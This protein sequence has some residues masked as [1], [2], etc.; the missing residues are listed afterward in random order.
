MLRKWK[1]QVGRHSN[2][3]VTLAHTSMPRIATGAAGGLA[4]ALVAASTC[5]VEDDDAASAVTA[6][7]D[8]DG[9]CD[10]ADE[11]C[12][13]D[14]VATAA[15]VGSFVDAETSGAEGK[16]GSAK[17]GSTVCTRA[18]Y[19]AWAA[20][21]LKLCWMTTHTHIHTVRKGKGQSTCLSTMQ[22]LMQQLIPI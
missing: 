7:P 12:V 9:P 20:A 21:E 5:D 3:T 11:V 8:A 15:T 16:A 17:L 1:I 10:G 22:L 14:D 13:G 2:M 4:E 6:A 18:M 19:L